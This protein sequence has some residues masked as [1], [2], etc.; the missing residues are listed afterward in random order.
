MQSET[1][2]QR[3]V[4]DYK[5]DVIIFAKTSKMVAWTCIIQYFIHQNDNT[6]LMTTVNIVENFVVDF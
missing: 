1:P 4:F 5:V 3:G 2:R 6:I